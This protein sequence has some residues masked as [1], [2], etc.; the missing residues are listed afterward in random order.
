MKKSFQNALAPNAGLADPC[1]PYT[2]N[3]IGKRQKSASRHKGLLV[4]SANLF[5]LM[6]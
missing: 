5:L 6:K 2:V 3:I 4:N 1:M